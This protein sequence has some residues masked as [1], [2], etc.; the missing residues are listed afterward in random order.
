[1]VIAKHE[2]FC[3]MV[4]SSGGKIIVTSRQCNYGS[5]LAKKR[6]EKKVMNWLHK[7]FLKLKACVD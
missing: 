3:S 7:N 4:K 5:K 2:S 6:K 1:M